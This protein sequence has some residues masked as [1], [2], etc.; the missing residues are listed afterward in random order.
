MP[1]RSQEKHM[2][3]LTRTTAALLLLSG[4][5][6]LAAEERSEANAS[7][8]EETKRV[9]VWPHGPKAQ[10]AARL[11]NRAVT[12]CDAKASDAEASNVTTSKG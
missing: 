4:C 6:V 7:C 3:K 8:R 2:K 5:S 11:E 10:P 9:V 1:E 12:V